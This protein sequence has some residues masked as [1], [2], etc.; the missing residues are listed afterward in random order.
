MPTTALGWR[1]P[2]VWRLYN[3]KISVVDAKEMRPLDQHKS[4]SKAIAYLDKYKAQPFFLAVG[5]VKPHSPPTAPKKF[6][7][8][9][10]ADRMDLPV[11]FGTTPKAPQGFPD[12]SITAPNSDLFIGRESPPELFAP[13]LDS[14][15]DGRQADAQL[16]GDFVIRE[17]VGVSK[18]QR[19]TERV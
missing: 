8:L 1:I 18:H 12:I 2:L 10:D 5:F 16:R 15:L 7:D 13:P 11:D 4:C 17:A 19:N 9:Y 3:D 6:F 14:H